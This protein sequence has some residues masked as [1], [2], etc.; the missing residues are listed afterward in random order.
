MALAFGKPTASEASRR[1]QA[2][3]MS[4]RLEAAS[5]HQLVGILYDELAK[6]LDVMFAVAASGGMLRADPSADR[7]STILA[8]LTAGLDF[9]RG[10]ELSASLASVYRA[11]AKKLAAAISQ[12]DQDALIELRSGVLT[13]AQSWE[14]IST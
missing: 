2:L 6:A 13:L 11:M 4:S 12:T 3:A 9:D 7:A 1:Y 5:P 10:G 14:K 8:A